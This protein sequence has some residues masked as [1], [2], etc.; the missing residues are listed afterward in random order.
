LKEKRT[1]KAKTNFGSQ[2]LQ[3]FSEIHVA[4]FILSISFYLFGSIYCV[5]LGLP[6]DF[7]RLLLGFLIILFLLIAMEFLNLL[8]TNE[9]D[10]DQVLFRR[11]GNLNY[12]L[13]YFILTI[14]SILIVT[15]IFFFQ[16]QNTTSLILAALLLFCILFYTIKPFRLI[17]SGYGEILQATFIAMLIPAFGYSLQVRGDLHTNLA[18]LCL[19]FFMLV[20]A[21]QYIIENRSLTHD[22][23]RYHTTAVMRFGSVIT[24]RIAIYLIAFSYIFMLLLGVIALPWRFILRWFLSVPVA[25]YLIWNINKILSGEKPAWPVITFLAYALVL[26]NLALVALSFLFI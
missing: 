19:P 7:Y 13:I 4:D 6:I 8:F 20:L 18:Y 17:Y 26:L 14:A 25:I 22:V 15:V 5:Y 24:L 11:F 21:L 3:T 1:Q 16:I 12:R 23:E 10:F 9:S 2:L